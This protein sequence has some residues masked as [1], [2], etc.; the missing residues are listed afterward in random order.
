MRPTAFLG[1]VGWCCQKHRPQSFRELDRDT[2]PAR[3]HPQPAQQADP[4]SSSFLSAGSGRGGST[5]SFCPTSQRKAE[6]AT[7]SS[8]SRC[9][10]CCA[11][12]SSTSAITTCAPSW[13]RHAAQA[14]PMPLAPPAPTRIIVFVKQVCPDVQT[15][16]A[17]T[18]Y[19]PCL[20]K[21]A[22]CGFAFRLL[23]NYGDRKCD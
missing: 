18:A 17:A 16:C 5:S 14:Y 4:G 8:C 6:A 21:L 20:H 15:T 22:R 13:P 7:P 12:V 3:P 19:V 10:A 9:A 23:R 11:A 2:S 1:C